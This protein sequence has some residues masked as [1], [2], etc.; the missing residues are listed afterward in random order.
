MHASVCA[1]FSFPQ[2]TNVAA[3]ELRDTPSVLFQGTDFH[4]EQ[5]ALVAAH[6]QVIYEFFE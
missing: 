4:C 1:S 3:D 6:I 5:V 2:V